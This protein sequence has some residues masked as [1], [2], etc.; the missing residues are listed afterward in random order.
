MSITFDATGAIVVGTDLSAPAGRALEWAAERAAATTKKLIVVFSL[1]ELT[2]PS[3]G[4]LLE[5]VVPT[6]WSEET[7]RT[8]GDRLEEIRQ[9]LT[10]THRGLTVET[11]VEVDPP[12]YVLAQSS[13]VA[14]L[15]VVGARGQHAPA[16]VRALGGTAD[17]TVAHAHGPVAVV[18]DLAE[19]HPE[20]PVVVGVDDSE[21]SRAALRIAFAEARAHGSTLK[22]LHAW[23]VTPWVSD[24]RTAAVVPLPP[25]QD[26]L[27]R[28][29][30]RWIAPFVE[31]EPTVE[32]E[33]DIV[34]LRPAQAL[35]D[36]SHG[37]RLL[38]VGSR[39]RGGFAG[40]L[41]GSTSRRTLREARCP[42]IVTRSDDRR[43]GEPK[44]R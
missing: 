44:S 32:V 42:V 6:D 39:G 26:D 13:K 8:A 7:R 2:M 17:V 38:V 34:E 12:S 43:V 5:T 28:A 37:A 22:A 31:G 24:P 30:E 35:I 36:A 41:L 25:M 33:V 19:A 3:Y 14:D 10:T 18:T 40:L 9:R 11:H 23:D 20:G 16:S 1:P 21:E 27:R 15:V 29:V 4:Q